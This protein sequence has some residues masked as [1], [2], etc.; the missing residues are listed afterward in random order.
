MVILKILLRQN[1]PIL[2]TTT[3]TLERACASKMPV[4]LPRF[5]RRKDPRVEWTSAVNQR[6]SLKSAIHICPNVTIA[7]LLQSTFNLH[8]RV[9]AKFSHPNKI[10]DEI[11]QLW[12]TGKLVSWDMRLAFSDKIHC[13]VEWSVY[14]SEIIASITYDR[15]TTFWMW[16]WFELY[17]AHHYHH[18]LL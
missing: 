3:I 13:F 16:I 17:L 10:M 8:L 15:V 2:H 12:N 11:K 5:T 6:E 9:I 4:T 7:C 1:S 14:Y 18:F